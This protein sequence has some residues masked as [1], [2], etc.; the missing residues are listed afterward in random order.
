MDCS[1]GRLKPQPVF[2]SLSLPRLTL[3]PNPLTLH[4][5][6]ASRCFGAPPPPSSAASPLMSPA[7]PA[8]VPLTGAS[9]L[10]SPLPSWPASRLPRPPSRPRRLLRPQPPAAM[11]RRMKKNHPRSPMMMPVPGPASP[12]T[13]P[14]STTH[15]VRSASVSFSPRATRPSVWV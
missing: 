13:A 2:F 5:S 12:S 4:Q 1:L 7:V 6:P 3:R 10:H 8:V 9:L 14:A 11:R 15:Q